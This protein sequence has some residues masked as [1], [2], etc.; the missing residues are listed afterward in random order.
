MRRQPKSWPGV[1]RRRVSPLWDNRWRRVC[2]A[3]VLTLGSRCKLLVRGPCSMCGSATRAGRGLQITSADRETYAR[4][5]ARLFDYGSGFFR[6][7]VGI[8]RRRIP[9]IT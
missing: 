1:C 4:F 7:G 3:A 5:A 8:C 9:P 2:V 6:A